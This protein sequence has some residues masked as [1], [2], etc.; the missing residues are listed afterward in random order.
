MGRGTSTGRFIAAHLLGG[1]LWVTA[2]NAQQP[3]TSKATGQ[4][5]GSRNWD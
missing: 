2:V 5:R 1:A 3:D 4:Q